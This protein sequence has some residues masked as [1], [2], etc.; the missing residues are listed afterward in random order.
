[1]A[2]TLIDYQTVDAARPWAPL[3]AYSR[4]VRRGG[5]IEV[6]GTSA[7]LP[8]GRV[9]SPGN[10]YEQ[11]AHVLKVILDAIA[12]LGGTKYDVIRTRAYLTN[13]ADWE[14]VGQAHGEVFAGIAPAST[15]VEVS[16]L[17]LPELVVEIEVTALISS[18]S[19]PRDA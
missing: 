2:A 17:L 1:M 3:I 13:I 9:V 7:T 19:E 18:L 4:A 16:R 5:V 11:T 6:G 10:A 8:D 15:F 14:A 12:E